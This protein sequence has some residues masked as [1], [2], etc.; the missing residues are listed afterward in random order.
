MVGEKLPL[1]ENVGGVKFFLSTLRRA[2]VEECHF[3]AL[4]P[5]PHGGRSK[6]RRVTYDV[7]FVM[8]QRRLPRGDMPSEGLLLDGLDSGIY[9]STRVCGGSPCRKKTS[10]FP[11]TGQARETRFTIC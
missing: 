6:D 3:V 5:N 11:P 8:A 9:R 2:L 1:S 10:I 7:F 4:H